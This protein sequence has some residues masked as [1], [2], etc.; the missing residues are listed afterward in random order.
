[1]DPK[2]TWTWPHAVVATVALVMASAVE[3][4]ALDL[5]IDGAMLAGYAA[6]VGAILGV[7]APLKNPFTGQS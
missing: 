6:L 1:M 2:P 4:H 5:K 7:L 3:W